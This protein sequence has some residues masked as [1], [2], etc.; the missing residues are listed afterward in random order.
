MRAP[1][2]GNHPCPVLLEDGGDYVSGCSCKLEIVGS[3]ETS[4]EG[5]A[6][7]V[8]YQLLATLTCPPLNHLVDQK[9]AKIVLMVE[10]ATIRK[11]YPYFDNIKIAI[12][13]YELRLDSNLE[14][15]PVIIACEPF[16][17]PYDAMHM[18]PM[19]GMFSSK[20]FPV[21]KDQI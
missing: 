14:I 13:P 6:T 15:T 5:F 18:D 21:E 7:S 17:L 16:D 19:Y 4:G 12:N 9:K 11:S 10:Q 3:P 1:N 2:K 8:T 20:V